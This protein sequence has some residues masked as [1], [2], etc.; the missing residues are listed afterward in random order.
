M[1]KDAFMSKK[2]RHEI[3]FVRLTSRYREVL[4]IILDS[5]WSVTI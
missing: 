2:L 1:I 4:S 3:Y 5:Q